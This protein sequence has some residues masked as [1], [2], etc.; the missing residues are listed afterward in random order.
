[1]MANAGAHDFI[2]VLSGMLEEEIER[3][4]D[5]IDILIP[6]DRILVWEGVDHVAAINKES[7][8][9]RH[10]ATMLRERFISTLHPDVVHIASLFEGLAENIVSSV[11][12]S[13]G[14]PLHAI[15]LYD[16]IPLA[17]KASYLGD[18]RISDW[19]HE[20]ISHLMRADMLLGISKY[21]C[22][23]AGE[24]LDIPAEKVFNIGGAADPIFRMLEG[25]E[26]ERFQISRRYGFEKP[27]IMYAGGFDP[28]KNIGELVKAFAS[29]PANIRS[30]YQLVIVG[31]PP[32]QERLQL[33]S[34][35]I[36]SGL[37][38]NDVVFAGY[39]PDMDL[40]K[41]YNLCHLYVF[42]SLQEGFGLPALEAM[43]CGAVVI[44][45]N[46]T[47][48]PEVIGFPDALFDP[49][50]ADSIAAK[51]VQALTDQGLRE[52]LKA[53]AK[54]QPRKFT[55]QQSAARAIEAFESTARK[56]RRQH[57]HHQTSTKP[58]VEGLVIAWLPCQSRRTDFAVAEGCE[59]DIFAGESCPALSDLPSARSLLELARSIEGYDLIVVE[60]DDDPY[61]ADIL[62]AL[63]K[64]SSPVHFHISA[65][66]IGDALR[67][68][69]QKGKAGRDL[70]AG[71]VYLV[72]GY[73]AVLRA[74]QVDWDSSLLS[75]LVPAAALAEAFWS[76]K[77]P[78][79]A[80]VDE[81]GIA[82]PDKPGRAHDEL[83]SSF[84]KTVDVDFASGVAD[85]PEAEHA[86]DNDLARI[87]QAYT[88]NS[89]VGGMRKQLLVDISTLA[90]RDAGTGIQRV[91]R[92]VLNELLRLPP[93]GFRVEPVFQDDTGRFRYARSFCATRY[94]GDIQLPADDLVEF[95][96]SDI[97]YGLDLT[98]HLV[99]QFRG[100]FDWMRQRGVEVY[101]L[102]HDLLPILRRDCFDPAIVPTFRAWYEVTSEIADGI[103][104]VSHAVAA[105]YRD[106]LEV[107]RP[108]RRRPIKIGV[109]YSGV[110]FNEVRTSDT[111]EVNVCDAVI[112]PLGDR[113]TFLMVGTVEPRKGCSQVLL[114]F[115]WL[116]SRGVD[117]NLVWIGKQGWLVEELIERVRSHPELGRRLFWLAA[118]ADD[119]LVAMYRRASAL[120]MAS[121]GEGF[122]LPIIEAAHY[123]VPL[124]LRDIAVFREVAGEHATY[125][126]GYDPESLGVAVLDWLDQRKL[127]RV[128]TSDG[129]SWHSWRKSADQVIDLIR[130]HHWPYSWMP[131]RRYALAA[132]DVRMESAV[133]DFR[134]ECFW[135]AGR[136]GLLASGPGVPVSAGR[137]RVALTGMW[138]GTNG[139][140]WLDLVSSAGN[141]NHL[142]ME[143][144][145]C[146]SGEMTTIM[147][148]YVELEQ[149]VDDL[150]LK[151]G[152][153]R[154]TGLAFRRL[155]L[156][157]ESIAQ[158]AMV[159]ELAL[160]HP[161]TMESK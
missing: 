103:V 127:G 38:P 90:V 94:L 73:A 69:I 49:R 27:F 99:P 50:R 129:L 100:T 131:G 96:Y 154:S 22:D 48:L 23:E 151:L 88:R 25:V 78:D 115:E 76:V 122:G 160:P 10:A 1:M 8:F 43:S 53:H 31:W 67:A 119:V 5:D 97:F 17:S 52:K 142:H 85:L 66:R 130:G 108:L 135:S 112:G 140:A 156:F 68:L 24:L 47:S 101:F 89:R 16:L 92:N 45:S 35:I 86:G 2:V 9:R 148:G 111:L 82:C 157:E 126:S 3:I 141:L 63:H 139:C 155:E 57:A 87:A 55:W 93:E 79:S 51:L 29:L 117:V 84:T 147:Q 104:C 159:T 59:V 37:L 41:L 143:M 81:A 105:E 6:Q 145:P 28:R 46:T 30:T 12:N 14:S 106:W 120:V 77:G 149:D 138:T 11:P 13:P 21:T 70:L 36:R 80:S 83:L 4:R 107:Y 123:G 128:V 54:S 152:V 42:P 32:K 61:I 98:A 134:R 58:R 7:R 62:L 75:D 20:R 65:D 137:Y 34:L 150:E 132:Y 74:Q 56:S 19:Y 60:L 121:E 64:I 44:G 118:A 18:A 133:G 33:E 26:S 125:F 71:I 116:W 91:V 15:T 146:R 102:L 124:L 39:V 40:V 113:I 153:G 158:P 114:A 110:E 109:A 72:G 144:L 136:Q 161:E 95:G